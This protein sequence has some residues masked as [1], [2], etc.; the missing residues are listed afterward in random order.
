M[1]GASTKSH[2]SNVSNKPGIDNQRIS[3]NFDCWTPNMP[4]NEKKGNGRVTRIIYN[5]DPWLS[6]LEVELFRTVLPKWKFPS[7]GVPQ[8]GWFLRENP[9]NMDDLGAPLF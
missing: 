7:M 1:T 4:E 8:N 3:M 5:N 9:T 6:L 2:T